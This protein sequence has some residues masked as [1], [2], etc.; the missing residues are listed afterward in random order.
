MIS[1]IDTNV[2][3][4]FFVKEDSNLYSKSIDIIAKIEKNELKV[5]ILSEV[6]MEILFIM[7]KYYKVPLGE[8]V[9]DLKT[10]LRLE[11]VVNKNKYIL[12]N[13]LDMMIEKNIDYVDAL[14]CS[15]SKLQGYGK[16]SFDKDVMTK[17]EK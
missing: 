11:G 9:K 7:T 12:I 17:C 8:I 13:S 15:K 2:I 14:I 3:I 10:I 16:I 6:I 4:R 1:L 5:E